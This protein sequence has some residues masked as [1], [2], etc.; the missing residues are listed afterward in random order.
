MISLLEKMKAEHEAVQFHPTLN[1]SLWVTEVGALPTLKPEVHT[2]LKKIS[3]HFLSKLDFTQDHVYN[4]LGTTPNFTLPV[5]DVVV[6]GSNANYNWTKN[7]D[8]DIHVVVDLSNL[9][10]VSFDFVRLYFD[11]QRQLWNKTHSVTVKGHTVEVYV[12]TSANSTISS[13]VYS[14]RN[15][16]WVVIPSSVSPEIN[17]AA[18]EEKVRS[19]KSELNSSYK[20]DQ[21]R[22]VYD[23]IVKLRKASIAVDGEFSV[24]NLAFKVLRSSGVLNTLSWKLRDMEDRQLSLSGK[25]T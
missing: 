1:P 7:S 8:I 10:G 15:S 25:S 16:S 20:E 23:K 14:L 24:E 3:D 22:A 17:H 12:E 18:V 2:A 13:G 19:I 11:G 6:T 5:S 21:L 9:G 4:A